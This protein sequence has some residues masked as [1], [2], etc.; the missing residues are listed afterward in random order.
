[1]NRFKSH[2]KH[3]IS[4]AIQPGPGLPSLS[5]SVS[6]VK[7]SAHRDP[8][9]GVDNEWKPPLWMSD[10]AFIV[11]YPAHFEVTAIKLINRTWNSGQTA[12]TATLRLLF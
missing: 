9:I 6:R 10:E 8:R 3:Y 7:A 1:M 4:T 5:P 11:V 2:D 12:Y